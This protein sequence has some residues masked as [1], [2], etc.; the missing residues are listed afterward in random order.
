MGGMQVLEWGVMYPRRCRGLLPIAT[1]VSATA[2]QIAYSSVQRQAIALDPGFHGGDYYDAPPG[3]GPHRGLALARA[4]AQITYRTDEVFNDRF[5]RTEVEELDHPDL[6]QRFSVEGY[7]DYH[8]LKLVRRFDANSYL[9]IAKAM[10][11]HD[12]ARARGGVEAA[13]S[14]VRCPVRTVSID[15]DALYPRYQQHLIAEVLRSMGRPASDV[16]IHSPHGHDAF[17]IETDQVGRAVRDFLEGVV[18][19][20]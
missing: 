14:R 10:D 2:Q 13:L 12:L 7:L 5:G 20:G 9:R 3:G 19:D 16:T 15:S 17:L 6:W 18:Q 4:L 8:G 1:S 11:L